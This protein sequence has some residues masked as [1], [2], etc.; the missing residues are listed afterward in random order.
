[1][2]FDELRDDLYARG[3]FLAGL[4]GKVSGSRFLGAGW[5]ARD[6]IWDMSRVKLVC[7]RAGFARFAGY[8]PFLS[9]CSNPYFYWF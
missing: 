7:G 6:G 3:L 5:G 4:D 9:G 1:V 8:W 2:I